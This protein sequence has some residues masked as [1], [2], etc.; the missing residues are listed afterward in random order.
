MPNRSRGIPSRHF[1]VITRDPQSSRAA[2]SAALP[3]EDQWTANRLAA[4]AARNLDQQ[5]CLGQQ[6][7]KT[8]AQRLT[9]ALPYLLGLAMAASLYV[10]SGQITYPAREGQ[11]GP[12]FWPRI[13]IGIIAAVCLYEI[14]RLL[15]TGS[16]ESGVQGI[17]EQLDSETD[18]AEDGGGAPRPHLL[19]GGVVLTVGYAVLMPMLGFLLASFLYLVLFMYLGGV[20]NHVAVWVTSTVGI[21]IFAFIFVKVVYISIPRGEPPFDR[22]TQFVMDVIRV[23]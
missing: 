10:L 13:A 6:W 3:L 22:V 2:A 11:L 14:V 9:A 17:T 20:R 7:G 18:V 1:G 15:L 16:A 23:R 4:T 5:L 21:F 12:H 19:L 8:M